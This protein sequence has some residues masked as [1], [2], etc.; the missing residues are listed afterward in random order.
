DPTDA[1]T[2]GFFL[3]LAL[4]AERYVLWFGMVAAPLIAAQAATLWPP[5]RAG[6]ERVGRPAANA[7]LIV[8]LLLALAGSLPWIKPLWLAPP[9]GSLLSADTPVEA[10]AAMQRQPDRPRHLLHPMQYGSYLIWAAPEQKVFID[11]RI[12]LYPLEQW[13]DYLDLEQGR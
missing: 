9:F 12:E 3:W 6:R 7:A 4:G 8:L 1:L 11:T 10:V 5:Q 13:L 2:F